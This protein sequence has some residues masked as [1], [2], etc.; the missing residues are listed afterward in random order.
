MKIVIT[1]ASSGLGAA[2]AAAYALPGNTLCLS[3]RDTA[4]LE[5]V[6][7]T[8]RSKGANVATAALDV[9]DRTAIAQWLQSLGS[10]DLLIANAGISA[11]TGG[12]GES[13]EQARRIF[14]VNLYG[15]LNSIHPLLPNNVKQIAIISSL[16]GLR[17]QPGAPAY[18]AS[19]GAVR[20]YGESLRMELA[21]KGVGVTVVCPGFIRTPMT[22]VNKFRMPWLMEAD[23]AAALI[24]RRLAANPPRIAF[25]WPLYA[26]VLLISWLPMRWADAILSRLPKK[27]AQK[28]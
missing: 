7:G 18:S 19:K 4:R 27:G 10:V 22:A 6:A 23:A 8:C 21:P 26:L 12:D 5:A 15:V 16:A 24:K 28:S 3:G 2:L 1:G 14:Y 25:P 20:M 17:G 9:T 11:G 13:E